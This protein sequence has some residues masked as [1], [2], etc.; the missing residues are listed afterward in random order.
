MRR[1]ITEASVSDGR[2]VSVSLVVHNPQGI[3]PAI[4]G[5]NLLCS[6]L[7]FRWTSPTLPSACGEFLTPPAA[8]LSFSF[9]RLVPIELYRFILLQAFRFILSMTGGLC[10]LLP[11]VGMESFVF[12]YRTSHLSIFD[13]FFCAINALE[14]TLRNHFTL[15][16]LYLDAAYEPG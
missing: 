14:R 8:L 5:I 1:S 16:A 15:H 11:S 12:C 7:P 9:S 13:G 3:C 6:K 10:T 4:V 2:R